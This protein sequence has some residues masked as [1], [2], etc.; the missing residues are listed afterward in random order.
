MQKVLKYAQEEDDCAMNYDKKE[1]DENGKRNHYR[2]D[3]KIS[4]FFYH[5]QRTYNLFFHRK[6]KIS[7]FS[8]KAKG[9]P[10]MR[11][12]STMPRS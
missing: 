9:L 2:K 11:M 4:S 8:S 7:A 6:E 3:I 5:K 1:E 10:I 12:H